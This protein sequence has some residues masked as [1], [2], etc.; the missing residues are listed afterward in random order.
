MAVLIWILLNYW[1]TCVPWNQN[2]FHDIIHYVIWLAKFIPFSS[3]GTKVSSLEPNSVKCSLILSNWQLYISVPMQTKMS[4]NSSSFQIQNLIVINSFVLHQVSC[5]HNS[6]H[7][8]ILYLVYLSC[9][10]TI[11]MS[12]H[13]FKH[14]FICFNNSHC[15]QIHYLPNLTATEM[16]I[17]NP[18]FIRFG[19]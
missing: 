2:Y 4:V 9:N 5:I 10:N 7:Y 15:A 17:L 8:I 11:F 18:V 6:F 16:L 14:L 3:E 13:M 19:S 1:I 12:V